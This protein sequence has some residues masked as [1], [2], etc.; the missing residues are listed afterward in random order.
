[1]YVLRNNKADSRNHC[2][3]G[4]SVSITYYE[5][6]FVAFGIQHAMRMRRIVICGLS[7]CTVFFHIISCT[8]RF[9]GKKVIEHKTCDLFPL[10]LSSAIFLI[11]DEFSKAL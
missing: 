2:C 7:D 4:K 3:S 10:Q 6:V 9:L 5:R 11:I 8:A 1:M